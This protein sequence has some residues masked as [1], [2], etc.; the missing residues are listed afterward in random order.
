[1]PTTP[2]PRTP[3]AYARAVREARES[4]RVERECEDAAGVERALAALA[5]LGVDE[6]GEPIDGA[7]VAS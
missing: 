1:V 6:A 7:A 3:H 4:L 5:A 2:I